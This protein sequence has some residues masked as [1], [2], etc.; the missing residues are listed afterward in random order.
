MYFSTIIGGMLFFIPILALYFQESLFTVT[1][2]ALLFSI[3]AIALVI[4]EVPS[5]AVGDLFGRK[6][7]LVLANIIAIIGLIFLW[8]GGSMIF[9]IIYVIFNG[10]ARSLASGTNAALIYDTL[11][12]EGHERQFK[13]IIGKYFSLW[14]LGVA[15]GSII[16]GY[17]A[18]ISLQTTVTFTFI[19]LILAFILTLFLKEPEYEKEDHKNV[20]KHMW[21]S[22]IKIFKNRQLLILFIGIL[23]ITMLG[24]PIHLMN[25]LYFNFKEIPIIYF[26]Y[27]SAAVF[28]VSSL[29]FYLSHWFSE[30]FGNK[31]SIILFIISFAFF[32]LLSSQF[33]GWLSIILFIIP[34]FFYGLRSPIITH[35]QNLEVSS[36]NRAT[37]MSISNF[38]GF[39][40]VAVFS[41]IYGYWAELY[42]INTALLISACGMFIVPVIFLMLEEKN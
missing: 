15:I 32:Y 41:P 31:L 26:G 23:V 9:F 21:R 37:V 20:A 29:G 22:G 33:I 14:P 27:I 6:N 7:T 4:F 18:S 24:E 40:G 8:I 19:P 10:L 38:A 16:G 1:N 36:S 17:L 11:K 39:I 12:E 25:S 34:S 3:E 35:L 30:K 13:K 2:V 42:T 28:G 5:G